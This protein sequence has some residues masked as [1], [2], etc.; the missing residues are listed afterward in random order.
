MFFLH[1]KVLYGPVPR[2]LGSATVNAIPMPGR[3]SWCGMVTKLDVN[4]LAVGYR[5][6]CHF[7]LQSW[8]VRV[9]STFRQG[10]FLYQ[11]C[12]IVK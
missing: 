10:Y 12:E 9:R 3:P 4:Q 1:G 11:V 8:V 7:N 5:Q 2:S 6:S